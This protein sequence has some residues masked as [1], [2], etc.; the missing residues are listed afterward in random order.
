MTEPLVS[1]TLPTWPFTILI[2]FFGACWGSFLNVLI[3]RIPEDMSVT[4]E[5]SK[6]TR[7]HTMIPWYE[8]IPILSY[9]ILLGRCSRCNERIDAQYPLIEM[10]GVLW[11][12]ALAKSQLLPLLQDPVAWLASPSPLWEAL[13]VWLWLQLFVFA[14]VVIIF[15]DLRYTF[16]P[17]EVSLTV[18]IL[19]VVGAVMIP[20]IDIIDT[21]VGGAMGGALL[22]GVR[23]VGALMF[24][25]EAMGLGDVKLLMM[26]GIFCGWRVLPIILFASAIQ[27]IL[28][29]LV[30]QLYTRLS[31]QQN[32]L[33][34][35]TSELDERFGEL[36]NDRDDSEPMRIAIPFGPFLALSA[37]E[38]IMLGKD[39]V[40]EM[41]LF[42]LTG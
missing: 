23:W 39:R 9:L 42:T 20:Q 11:A 14:L 40:I 26:I 4:W 18:S 32:A 33:T 2:L 8:N 17:D 22:L 19:G 7:C 37:F 5:R 15:I 34:L 27:G 29:A 24:Q 30:A 21:L 36:P 3:Y 31:G 13:G 12:Y 38:V 16:I 10:I 28:A 1:E 6:C 41:W 25:R 35:T